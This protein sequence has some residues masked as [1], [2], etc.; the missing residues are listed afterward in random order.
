VPDILGEDKMRVSDD[1]LGLVGN[2]VDA[3]FQKDYVTVQPPGFHVFVGHMPSGEIQ[4][5]VLPKCGGALELTI[6]DEKVVQVLVR[7]REFPFVTV[8]PAGLNFQSFI[9]LWWPTRPSGGFCWPGTRYVTSKLLG[10][11]PMK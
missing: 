1:V 8:P 11:K 3:N 9:N 5:R 4:V 7:F 10:V 6:K 2:L